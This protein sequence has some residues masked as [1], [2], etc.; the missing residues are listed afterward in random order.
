VNT[1]VLTPPVSFADVGKPLNPGSN[2][3]VV[4]PLINCNLNDP[5]LNVI[6]SPLSTILLPLVSPVKPLV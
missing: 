6:V 2:V 5:L 4:P 3:M 1:P